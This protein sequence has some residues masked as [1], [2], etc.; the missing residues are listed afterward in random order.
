MNDTHPL[1][2]SSAF[3]QSPVW[4]RCSSVGDLRG[5]EVLLW[6]REGCSRV[7]A[8]SA[9]H[10]P[11]G[12]RWP[13]G[14]RRPCRP[15][16]P[17]AGRSRWCPR[18]PWPCWSVDSDVKPVRMWLADYCDSETV[19]FLSYFFRTSGLIPVRAAAIYKPAALGSF[20]ELRLRWKRKEEWVSKGPTAGGYQTHNLLITSDEL[21]HRAATA[22]AISTLKILQIG[23]IT[24][25]KLHQ[26]NESDLFK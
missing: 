6:P 10:R 20:A 9:C 19:R 22:A 2:G 13:R 14:C 8:S 4:G 24:I 16:S 17:W 21:Y 12:A 7:A 23:R 11:S 26:E 5:G 1:W 3:G 25:D 18:C 15:R